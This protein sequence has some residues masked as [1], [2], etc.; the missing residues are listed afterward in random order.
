MPRTANRVRMQHRAPAA[1]HLHVIAAS[2][3]RQSAHAYA[4]STSPGY[5]TLYSQPLVV[6]IAGTNTGTVRFTCEQKPCRFAASDQ[7]EEVRRVD[8]RS[9]D[10]DVKD[11]RAEL[12]LTLGTDT[13]PGRYTVVARPVV[14][15]RVQAGSAVRFHLTI[16]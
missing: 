9:Y 7:P 1:A 11:G 10:V 14:H 5:E 2:A 3:L 16:E 6:R 4:A 8:P 12:T 13:V 15:K